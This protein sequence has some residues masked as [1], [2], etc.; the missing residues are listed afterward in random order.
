MGHHPVSRPFPSVPYG[1][2]GQSTGTPP[3]RILCLIYRLVTRMGRMGHS[4]LWWGKSGSC[5]A[6]VASQAPGVGE[7]HPVRAT[8]P[9]PP[10]HAREPHRIARGALALWDPQP[11]CEDY[12]GSDAVFLPAVLRS[13]LVGLDLF[14]DVHPGIVLQAR[15]LLDLCLLPQLARQ[16]Q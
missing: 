11:L 9:Q 7:I 6:S 12:V 13:I 8:P 1:T 10:H 5:S 16:H 3:S 15:V 4:I 2:D 14:Q